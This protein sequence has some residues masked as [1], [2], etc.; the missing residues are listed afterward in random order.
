MLDPGFGFSGLVVGSTSASNTLELASAVSA[1]TVAGLGSQY[2]HFQSI[3]FDAEAQWSIAGIQRGLAGPITGL[4]AGDTIE[5]TGDTATG[6]SFVTGVLT[7]DLA[8]GGSA[9][10]DL[11]GTFT[12]ASDFH[13]T[14]VAAGAD[15]TVAC[16]AAGTRILTAAGEVP[17]DKLRFGDR[18]PTLGSGLAR[19]AWLGHRRIDCRRHTRPTD[20][21]PVRVR[22]GAFGERLPAR[23]LLLSPDHAVLVDHVL[24]PIRHLLNGCTVVQEPVAEVV[25]Y[26]LE[27][28]AHDVILAEGLP[29]ESYLDTGDRAAFSD[30]ETQAAGT[31]VAQQH[32]PTHPASWR[33]PH[34]SELRL[35]RTAAAASR[36]D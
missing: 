14:N 4:A 25:Y 26:H 34:A 35:P 17:I 1:G 23:D 2:L 28:T 10:L 21:W 6:S 3:V 15:V 19:I 27:L 16:F 8:G 11:P 22:A 29:C 31:S 24:V 7:L 12:S 30:D 13:V 36:Q 9:T 32:D 20:A 18:V 33:R 5:L